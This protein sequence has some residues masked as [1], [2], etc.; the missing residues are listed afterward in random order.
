VITEFRI[1]MGVRYVPS[2]SGFK[3]NPCGK[4]ALA[5]ANPY[6]YP[7]KWEQDLEFEVKVSTIS[8][9]N[10]RPSRIWALGNNSVYLPNDPSEE[11]V[12]NQAV[13][14]IKPGT[15][16]AGEARAYTLAGA[17]LRARGT[18]T[19]RVTADLVPFGPSGA[20][21]KNCI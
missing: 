20:D 13:F 7:L 8:G 17:I 21:F 18:G 10:N 5:L 3:A 14:T 19:R 12:F 9:Y 1:L 11:A 6:P 16:P 15:L 2:G 4:I